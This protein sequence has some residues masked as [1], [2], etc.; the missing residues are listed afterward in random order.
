[1]KTLFL[2]DVKRF[3]KN[4]LNIIYLLQIVSIFLIGFMIIMTSNA[5]K[6]A[7]KKID[8]RYFNITRTIEDIHNVDIDTKTGKVIPRIKA[9][10][11]TP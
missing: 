8:F 11:L 6:S 10:Q 9:S 2:S 1:M 3:V 4:K 5:I 7:E